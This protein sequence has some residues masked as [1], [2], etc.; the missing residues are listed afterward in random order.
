MN[1]KTSWMRS[2]SRLYTPQK[3]SLS[4]NDLLIPRHVPGSRYGPFRNHRSQ[5][6][7]DCWFR[8]VGRC[9]SVGNPDHRMSK[10]LPLPILLA[11]GRPRTASNIVP[12]PTWRRNESGMV[13]VMKGSKAWWLSS[14]G[15]SPKAC[16]WCVGG[17]TRNLHASRRPSPACD[18]GRLRG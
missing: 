7:C 13:Q 10:V 17:A 1:L 3:K 18:R 14:P 9:L 16:Y 12:E 6:C 15:T 4:T 2:T 5:T 8:L 11:M